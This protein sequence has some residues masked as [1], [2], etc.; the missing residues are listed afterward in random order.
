M[1]K[2]LSRQ[3]YLQAQAAEVRAGLFPS[4]VP[5][6]SEEAVQSQPHSRVTQT[7]PP[8]PP[9]VQPVLGAPCKHEE[10]RPHS[11]LWGHRPY[12]W[13]ACCSRGDTWGSHRGEESEA[14][15]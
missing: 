8:P 12:G 7:P 9:P 3:V 5:E 6:R 15:P 13:Q 10:A 14:L 4:R 2:R 1:E 11:G